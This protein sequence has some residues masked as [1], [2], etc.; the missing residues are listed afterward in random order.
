MNIIFTA[1]F[2]RHLRRLKSKSSLLFS[3]LSKKLVEVCHNPE[4]YKPLKGL[5]KGLRRAHIGSFVLVFEV[6]GDSV[7][8]HLVEHH[9]YAYK[10][11]NFL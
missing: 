3:Q 4:H 8:F 6:V 2:E 1:C 7:V 5:L 10:K 11:V 9:D